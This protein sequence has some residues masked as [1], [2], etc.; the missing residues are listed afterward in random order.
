M[1]MRKKKVSRKKNP[2]ARHSK[3]RIS[4]KKKMI[5]NNNPRKRK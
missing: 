2:A 3:S 5:R 1:A 4:K